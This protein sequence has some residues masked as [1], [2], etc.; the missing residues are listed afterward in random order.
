MITH[1]ITTITAGASAMLLVGIVAWTALASGSSSSTVRHDT[2][3]PVAAAPGAAKAAARAAR[4]ADSDMIR[5]REVTVRGRN[6]DV[7]RDGESPGDYFVFESRL[8]QKGEQ[9]GRDFVRCMLGVRT[10]TCEGTFLLAG[11]GKIAVAG[12]LF[13]GGSDFRL[14]ITGGTG[15]FKGARGQLTVEEG[16]A[17]F[18]AFE[19]L[20]R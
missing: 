6:I 7:G 13:S 20:P 17:T 4:A 11:R 8:V 14:P 18:L 16:K 12:T 1:R 10:F 5:V 3:W 9:V 2:S 15:V 19:L